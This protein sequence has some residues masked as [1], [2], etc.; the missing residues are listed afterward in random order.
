MNTHDL[1]RL[2]DQVAK[3]KIGTAAALERLRTLPYE[4]LGFA[5]VDN[6]RDLRRGF[7]EVIYGEGK[8]VPQIIAIVGRLASR[9]QPVLVTRVGRDVYRKVR[10]RFKAAR[11][12]EQARAITLAGPG[13]RAGEELGRGAGGAKTGRAAGR[14]GGEGQARPGILVLA[15]GTSDLPVA[16]E[17]ALTAEVM[18]NKVDRIYDVGIAGLHRLLD[19]RDRI[20][21]ARVIV[22]IAGME[23]ALPSI[24][25]SLVRVPVI[26]VPTSIGY[27]TGIKG[28]AALMGMLNSCA[29]GLTVVNIDNGFGAGY[30]ASVINNQQ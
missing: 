17:A 25:A 9:R 7:P 29:S 24:V 8:T 26:G 22:V 3:K 19:H 10:A 20:M 30:A 21:A 18:G 27:G 12:H 14:R 23:G 13:H 16:E 6:H 15:A 2:I 11:Y 5:K 4:D 1:K 28:L